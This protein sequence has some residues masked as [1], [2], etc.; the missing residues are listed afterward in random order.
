MLNFLTEHPTF[1]FLGNCCLMPVLFT[2]FGVWIGRFRPR[3]RMPF[4]MDPHR[5]ELEEF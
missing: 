4:T 1:L 3:L 5:D 2:L